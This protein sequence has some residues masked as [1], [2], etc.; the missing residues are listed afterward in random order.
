MNTTYID[1]EFWKNNYTNCND[2]SCCLRASGVGAII[3]VGSIFLACIVCSLIVVAFI[4]RNKCSRAISLNQTNRQ[5]SRRCE[6]REPQKTGTG[7]TTIHGDVTE[8]VYDVCII[9]SEEQELRSDNITH[10]PTTYYKRCIAKAELWSK[11]TCLENFDQKSLSYPFFRAGIF[12]KHGGELHFD[13]AG[14]VLLIPPGAI[15]Q[16]TPQLIYIYL[17]HEQNEILPLPPNMMA[18]SPVVF[19]GPSGM[20]FDQRVLLSYQHCAN[21]KNNNTNL[22]TLRTETEPDQSPSFHNLSE[23]NDSLTLI[24]GNTV[25][26]LLSHFTGHTSVVQCEEKKETVPIIQEKWLNLML[27]SSQIN[28]DDYDLQLRLYCANQT[29]DARYI[30]LEDERL[31]KGSLCA[32]TFPFLFASVSGINILLNSE[33]SWKVHGGK[34][35][36]VLAKKCIIE[37]SHTPCVYHLEHEKENTVTKLTGQMHVSQDGREELFGKIIDVLVKKQQ[38]INEMYAED[39]TTESHRLVRR[40]L[41][42]PYPLRECIRKMLDIHNPLGNDWRHLAYCLGYDDCIHQWEQQLRQRLINSPTN[43]LLNVWEAKRSGNPTTD[44]EELTAMFRSM[45]RLDIVSEIG[46]WNIIHE[47]IL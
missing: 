4:K 5:P 13:E 33:G 27:F 18:T 10:K 44:I 29:K 38:R 37:N 24:K 45:Q 6:G 12:D 25:T 41:L 21:I 7:T 15:Q 11:Q 34:T 31:L 19:C 28:D 17:H 43:E 26:L 35:K 23:H 3:I 16:S 39:H 8:N 22:I 9:E 40:T 47:S 14:V 20:V 46:K 2:C 30:V 32:P 36:Q 1:S 42:L